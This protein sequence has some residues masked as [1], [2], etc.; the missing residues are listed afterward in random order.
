MTKKI[1]S[2]WKT[3]VAGLILFAIA[4]VAIYQDPSVLKTAEIQGL[5]AAGSGLILAGDRKSS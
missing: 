2:D 3:T 4:G 1:L 5:I